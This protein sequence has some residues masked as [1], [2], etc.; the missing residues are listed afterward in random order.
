M[1]TPVTLPFIVIYVD[2]VGTLNGNLMYTLLN[3]LYMRNY[4]KMK[5]NSQNYLKEGTPYNVTW[6][7]PYSD[8]LMKRER[9]KLVIEE[10]VLDLVDPDVE[11]FDQLWEEEEKKKRIKSV[12]LVV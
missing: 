11:E 9:E 5:K 12:V 6:G 7:K 4:Q 10:Y 3:Q 2:F 8:L 1:E